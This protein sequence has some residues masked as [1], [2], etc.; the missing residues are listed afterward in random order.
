MNKY[1]K[2]YSL[3]LNKCLDSSELI[4]IQE[5][6]NDIF[7]KL[8][9]NKSI[10]VF[11]NGGSGSNAIHIV[12]DLITLKKNLNL[13]KSSVYSLNS[14]VAVISCI[15][16]DFGY[17]QIFSEQI[18]LQLKKGDLVIPLSGSGNSQ[19]ILKAIKM[20]NKMGID[21]FGIFGFDGGRAK[22]MCKKY[23][24][25]DVNDMQVSEDMQ[26]IIFHNC[27]KIIYEKNKKK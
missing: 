7:L 25:L 22:K 19:N 9:S 14:N 24:H 17:D 6:S 5:L 3:K 21:T 12:N 11:G 8:K 18:K 10:V 15:A 13:T 26:T 20:S 23:I 16:N 4:K 1:L 2:N 27:C